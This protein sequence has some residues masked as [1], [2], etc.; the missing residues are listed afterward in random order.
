MGGGVGGLIASCT[1]GCLTGQRPTQI[2]GEVR[3]STPCFSACPS[4]SLT[5][6]LSPQP[7]VQP[8]N[9]A[10]ALPGGPLRPLPPPRRRRPPGGALLAP[11]RH[12]PAPASARRAE[13]CGPGDGP[14]PGAGA[15]AGVALQGRGGALCGVPLTGGK[16]GLDRGEWGEAGSACCSSSR[17]W[18]RRA[19]GWRRPGQ[20]ARVGP[21]G[22]EEA[23]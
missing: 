19:A 16:G 22:S 7:R 8:R 3:H 5:R 2:C 12:L 9:P 14:A 20:D 6:P 17:C 1:E 21:G 13:L 23:R 11:P 10:P 4:P 18:R 15:E